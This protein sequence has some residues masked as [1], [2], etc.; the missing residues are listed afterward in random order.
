MNDFDG[1]V[2]V[3]SYNIHRCIGLDRCYSPER[4]VRVIKE[5]NSDIIGLQEID[6]QFH[7]KRNESQIEYLAEATGLNVVVGP[8]LQR[9]DGHYGNA[10]FTSHRILDVRRI[11]LSVRGREPRGAI[12][13]DLDIH[14]KVMRVI[15]AH[16]GLS[17][18]ER[19]HQVG[20]LRDIFCSEKDR[21][22]M[23]LGDFNEWFPKR[24]PL[25]WLHD[26]FGKPPARLTYPAFMPMLAL[27][28]IWVRPLEMLVDMK[29]HV[30]P[31]SR[32]A[33]DHLPLKATL[34]FGNGKKAP[35]L[36]DTCD[37]VCD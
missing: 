35:S 22:E 11:D 37:L 25:C 10:L 4:I 12:D 8:T 30:T 29:V 13:V 2:S 31:L 21:M 17:F 36:L 18:S 23:M 5:L 32:I 28:R 1:K 19:R 27:D 14:G 34:D 16:L 20:R 3:A 24:K 15:V 33:S 6:S 26:Y 9:G 7:K